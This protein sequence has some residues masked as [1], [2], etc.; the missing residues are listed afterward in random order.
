MASPPVKKTSWLRE[1]LS[2]KSSLGSTG[3]TAT[4]DVQP[5]DL[6]A[7]TRHIKTQRPSPDLKDPFENGEDDDWAVLT[8]EK[9]KG[10]PSTDRSAMDLNHTDGMFLQG[11]IKNRKSSGGLRMS[12][13]VMGRRS[14]GATPGTGGAIKSALKP[15]KKEV[16]PDR[17]PSTG[18]GG[19]GATVV[20]RH[21]GRRKLLVVDQVDQ[22]NGSRSVSPNT[23]EK[24]SS[25]SRRKNKAVSPGPSSSPMD[26]SPSAGG[27]QESAFAK[28]RDTL[29]IQKAK[30]KK[31]KPSTK[32]VMQYSVPDFGPSSSKYQDP[33]EA[34]P[35]FTENG[36]EPDATGHEFT[37]VNIPHNRPEYCDHCGQNA[38]GHH[39]VLKCTSE[40]V[41]VCVCW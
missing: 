10:P 1:K 40:C 27:Y 11:A 24:S 31:K 36:E 33:F 38:W 23:T 12:S 8:I 37:Y 29:R 26:E 14:A 30:K 13:P 9:K 5:F 41:C 35:N 28:V 3:H 20:R 17:S 21:S 2:K 25:G 32:Q 7:A 16:A 4:T 19:T 22:R 15:D 6:T 34:Q 18:S 39:Q